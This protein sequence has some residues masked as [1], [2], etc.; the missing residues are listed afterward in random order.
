[1]AERNGEEINQKNMDYTGI[2]V[3]Y[4]PINED[5]ARRA[6][7]MNSFLITSREVRQQNTGAVWTRQFRSRNS[8]RKGQTPSTM[9]RSTGW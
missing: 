9:K 2:P 1:M 8:R 4:Y 5:A 6:K 3:M 7:E